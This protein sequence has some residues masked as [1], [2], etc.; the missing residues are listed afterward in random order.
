MSEKVETKFLNKCKTIFGIEI[1]GRLSTTRGSKFWGIWSAETCRSQTTCGEIRLVGGGI[2]ETRMQEPNISDVV[3]TYTSSLRPCQTFETN[4]SS[5]N[6]RLKNW[7]FVDYADIFLQILKK[8]CH[9]YEVAIFSNFS[10]FYYLVW[11]FLICK[12]SRPKTRWFTKVLLSHIFADQDKTTN[13]RD[14]D[15][16]NGKSWDQ[17]HISRLYHGLTCSG[18]TNILCSKCKVHLRL[19][20]WWSLETHICES[21]SRRLQVS[22]LWMLQRNSFVK[23]L[24]STIFVCC[25]CR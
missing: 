5:K 23:F 21:R 12:Y 2:K 1:K 25:I 7:K 13:L 19:N 24:K 6:P 3:E 14:W 4:T 9:N 17:D 20:Q 18:E 8:Y 15:S 11:L 10:H 16:K 22:R